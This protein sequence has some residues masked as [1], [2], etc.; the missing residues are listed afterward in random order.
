MF[1]IDYML[2]AN[3]RPYILEGNALPGCTETSLVP[4]AARQAGMSFA[5]MV[6]KLAMNAY[7]RKKGGPRA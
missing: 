4:K 3:L 1:R 6:A 2:D 7:R 5:R